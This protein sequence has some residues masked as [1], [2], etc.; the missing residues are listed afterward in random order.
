MN[1]AR[2]FAANG[3]GVLAILHDLNLTAMYA[4]HVVLLKNGLVHA[5][6]AP[7][8][9]LTAKNLRDVYD[10]DLTVSRKPPSGSVFVL[11]HGATSSAARASC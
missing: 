9:V 6:G 10:C 4:D 2:D 5:E 3:G 1:V 7:R 8:Q 11:P